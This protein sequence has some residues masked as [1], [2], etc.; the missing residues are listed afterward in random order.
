MSY[1]DLIARLEKAG[2]ADQD[3][4]MCDAIKYA[5]DSGWITPKQRD[6]AVEMILAEAY[7]SA[8][9]ML[10]PDALPEHSQIVIRVE[11]DKTFADARIEVRGEYPG[12]ESVIA[13]GDG[14]TSGIALCIAALKARQSL[15]SAKGE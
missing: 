2:D 14:P 9:L 3:R 13:E 1:Q 11:G 6:R 4:V 8:A 10:V 7:E 15:A 12:E 5:V